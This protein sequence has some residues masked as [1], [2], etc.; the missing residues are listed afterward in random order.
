M[1]RAAALWL[2]LGGI[3]LLIWPA[4]LYAVFNRVYRTYFTREFPARAFV[5]AGPLL[6]DGRFELQ[7]IAVKR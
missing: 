6:Y 7:G 5:G 4:L 2:V 3:H 1:R